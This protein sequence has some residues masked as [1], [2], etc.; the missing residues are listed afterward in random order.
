MNMEP[1]SSEEFRYEVEKAA[2]VLVA[3]G[4]QRARQLDIETP[5][6]ATVVY[7]GRNVAFVFTLDK[8]DSVIDLVVMRYRDG[9][10]LATC[11]GGYSSNLF[12][13]LVDYC[14]FRG[15]RVRAASLS[16]P[17]SKVKRMIAAL[18]NLLEQPCAKHLLADRSDA[19]PN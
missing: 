13:Y 7:A 12:S 3:R 17:A 14:G 19:L 18:M 4:F 8:R 11:D 16:P 2:G 5:T 6:L 10:L 1:I 15:R 9:K